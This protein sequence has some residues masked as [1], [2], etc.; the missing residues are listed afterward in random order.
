MTR[1]LPARIVLLSAAILLLAVLASRWE[2][3]V[4]AS[5]AF[6]GVL[7]FHNDNMRTG[8]NSSETTLT[9]KNV[10]VNTFGK[11]F[12]IP[13]DGLVD[14]QPLYTPNLSIPGNG[15][16][17]VLFWRPKMTLCTDSTR[18]QA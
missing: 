12:V 15:T 17:N 8:R 14:A 13:T 10:N 3:L 9:L 18:I 4:G 16:H 5:P 2:V 7:T 6:K 11:L 1:S